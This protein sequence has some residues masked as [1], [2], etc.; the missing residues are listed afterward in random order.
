MNYIGEH[1]LPGQVGHFLLVL[2]VV[3][4]L[5]A[6]IA[7]Y[8]AATV[9]LLEEQA[10]WRKLARIAYVVDG[11]SVFAVF[12]IIYYIISSHYFEYHYA[13]NHS[14]KSLGPGYLISSIWEGQEGS[15]LLWAMWHAVLGGMLIRKAD[16]WE[17]P[18]M[19][20]LSFCQVCLST[21]ILGI[22][23]FGVKVGSNPFLLTRE[24]FQDAPIFNRPDYLSLASMQDG[25][26]LNQLLQNYWMVIHPP[27][28]F[29]GFASTIVPFGYAIAG[30]WKKEHYGWTKASLPWSL[31]SAA[32][33]GLGIMMGARWAYE[34]LS[35]GGFWAWDP[36]EN[37]SL[38]AWLVMV[39]GIH[40]QII[41]NSTGHSLRPTYF[42]FLTSFLLI[43]Y[44]TYL[45]R[46]GDLQDTSVHAFTGS[47]LNWQL[48]AFLLV[49]LLPGY[50][51]YVRRYKNIPFVAKEE[52][53]YS[54]EFWMF[55]GS[56]VLFLSAMFII[57]F[58]SLPVINK[59]FN[60][61][62]TVGNEVEFFYNRIQI[63][64]AIV[65]GLL[66]AITQY[67]KYKNTNKK[68]FAKRII[69]PTVISIA[70]AVSI[71][72]FGNINYNRFGAGFL[73]AIHLGVFAAIYAVVA[74]ISYVW[75]GLGGKLRAAGASVGHVGFGILLI[76]I[77]I[78]SSKEEVVSI[79]HFNPLNFGPDSDQ[80][81]TENMTLFKGVRTDMGKYWA[82]YKKD[83][84]D[85]FNKKT[86]FHIEI[87]KKADG[88]KFTLVPDLIKN[89]KGQEGLSANPDA[90][91]YWNHDIFSYISYA[92]VMNKDSD[93]ARYKV[94]VMEVGDTVYYSNGLMV[95]D[96]VTPNPVTEKFQFN[97][98]DTAIMA[99]LN[100]YSTDGKR[101]KANPVFYLKNN[102]V[103][104][105]MDTVVSEGLAI[106]LTEIVDNKHIGI[107]VK[108]SSQLTPF[109][110]LKV[111][112]FPFINLVWLGT[113][114][115]IAGFAMS[116]VRRVRLLRRERAVQ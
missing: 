84:S 93:T 94:H 104:Y 95:L 101:F 77:L 41:Y 46:S 108:E 76:G 22:Y 18:V 89:T 92:E 26:G 54:R 15:F 61:G 3:S 97:P 115:M 71:S 64:V 10:G 16:R 63:F 70:I 53:N 99:E 60:S 90:K 110:A 31:F 100:V 6:T 116:I 14:D 38:V 98:T 40:T 39:A 114:V 47:G 48:R 28:L 2:S 112:Q 73:A 25:N 44:S 17:A 106:G 69:V 59:I 23:V 87:E 4:S 7:Y 13:W 45:T 82:T 42:F 19:S 65:L 109:I 24:V 105:H 57:L 81:G 35:F 33:L 72:L 85:K 79:N 5:V 102:V 103:Q 32:I 75:A 29:L 34:S 1:L 8:K 9:T 27:V 11:I 83:S 37:T 74:N 107:A 78:A 96:K 86:Y 67:L 55:I 80:K 20:V 12:G 52:N 62:F 30:L 66:T 50:I 111:L 56:L 51:L 68:V 113:I 36:V 58:T 49:F 91:H 43:L 88:K 21:M